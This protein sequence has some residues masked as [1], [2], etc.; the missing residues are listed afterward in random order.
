MPISNKKPAHPGSYVRENIIPVGMSVT[1]AANRLG[2]GRPALS[3]FLN[4]KSALSPEMAIRLEKALLADL[5]AGRL[6]KAALLK[7]LAAMIRRGLV[8]EPQPE[9]RF[10][11]GL[12]PVVAIEAEEVLRF[13]TTPHLRKNDFD[14]EEEGWT[15]SY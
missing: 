15:V 9:N 14:K 12:S 2:I 13:E 4:G 1:D 10:N 11:E 5:E 8:G 6:R 7:Y 3:N